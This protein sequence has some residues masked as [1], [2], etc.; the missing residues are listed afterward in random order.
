MSFAQL[1]SEDVSFLVVH[2]SATPPKQDI[3]VNEITRMHRQRGFLTIGYH[4]VIRRNGTVEDG[5]PVTSIGAHVEGFNAHSIG[6]CLVGGLDKDLKPQNNFTEDQFAALAVLLQKLRKDF[7][8]AVIQG[9]RDFPKVKKECPCF[10]VREWVQETIDD[11][12]LD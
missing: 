5:R 11:P 2:C 12:K 10:D 8:K 7:P 1:R 9:H 6:I 3:G 4:F